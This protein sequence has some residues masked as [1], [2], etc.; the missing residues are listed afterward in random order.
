MSP[1]AGERPTFFPTP[2][3]DELLSMILEMS[4]ELWV[5]R[6][7][8][9]RWEA[10]AVAEGLALGRAVEILKLDADQEAELAMAREAFTRNLFR[11]LGRLHAPTAAPGDGPAA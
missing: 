8:L 7:R 9:F 1:A 10:A 11:S 3:M 4:A 5:V 6:E 2:G